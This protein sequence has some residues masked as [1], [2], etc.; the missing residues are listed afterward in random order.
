M[1]EQHYDFPKTTVKEVILALL[2]GLLAPL[3]VIFLIVNYIMGIQATHI[4][5][6]TPGGSVTVHEQI[7][8]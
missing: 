5:D 8:K 7:K 6:A 4:D 3:I 2:G 1:S